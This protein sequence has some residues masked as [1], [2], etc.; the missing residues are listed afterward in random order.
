[1]EEP[2]V[3]SLEILLTLLIGRG[4]LYQRD[5]ASAYQET[6]QGVVPQRCSLSSR[7]ASWPL[8]LEAG[9]DSFREWTCIF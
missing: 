6:R 5:V 8:C 4:L 7:L 9:H 3:S 1:M 2:G